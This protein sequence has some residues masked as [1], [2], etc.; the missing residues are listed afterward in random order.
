MNSPDNSTLRR[1]LLHQ[2]SEAEQRLLEERL[3]SEEGVADALRDVE[4]DLLDDYAA[5]RLAAEDRASVEKY[6]LATVADRRRLQ[7]AAALSRTPNA[8]SPSAP[9]PAGSPNWSSVASAPEQVVPKPWRLRGRARIALVAAACA[10][11]A[12]I[13]LPKIGRIGSGTTADLVLL[14]DQQRGAAARSLEIRAPVARLRLQIEVSPAADPST[15]VID[16]SD[17]NGH[18]LYEA[19]RLTPRTAG[20]YSFV[21]MSVPMSVLNPAVQ[22]IIVTARQTGSRGQPVASVWEVSLNRP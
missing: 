8:T 1:L 10:I 12:I 2:T 7:I 14:A 9:A 13:A 6:L 19:E 3:L 16:V 17:Q 21:E 15:Y 4:N 11:L 22:R 18:R 5:K 20:G